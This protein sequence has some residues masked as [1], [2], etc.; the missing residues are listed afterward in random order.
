MSKDIKIDFTHRQSAHCENGVTSNLL[1]FHGIDLSEPMVFG[2]GAGLFFSY[3]PFYKLNGLPVISFRP[4]PG[5]IFNRVCRKLGIKLQRHKFP[6]N[7]DKAMKTLDDLLDNG[8]PTGCLVGVFHLSYFP[9]AYRFHFNAHNL[10]VFGRE[11]DRYIISDPIMETPE[12]LSYDELKRVRYAKGTYPPK[13]RMYFMKKVPETFDL[14][15]A[16]VQGIKKNSGQMLTIP[17][18]LFGVKG[19]RYMAKKMK[20]WP[21]KL[22]DRKASL[23]LGQVVRMLEEIGTGGAGFRFMYAAFLQES[24]RELKQDWLNECSEEMTAIGDRWREFAL[25]AGRIFKGREG[26]DESYLAASDILLEIADREEAL[27]RKLRKIKHG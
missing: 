13:G 16:I 24:A 3:M 1:N 19:I 5:W 6:R 4:Y 14:K 27:F 23:Y 18:P 8:V 25:I 2:L 21:K 9:E 17:V 15:K 11:E 26:K 20:R 10:V 7:P 22:G 12:T